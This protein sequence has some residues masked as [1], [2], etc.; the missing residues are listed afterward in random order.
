MTRST[1][2]E[3]LAER[4]LSI[5]SLVVFWCAFASLAAGLAMWVRDHTTYSAALLLM[6]G[7]LGLLV[8]PLLRLL[9]VLSSAIS[10]R[11]RLT[12]MTTLAVLAILCALTIRDAAGL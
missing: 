8:M 10:E 7:L 12:L 5:V 4:L 1:A 6:G 2:A 3:S 11:D 9:I